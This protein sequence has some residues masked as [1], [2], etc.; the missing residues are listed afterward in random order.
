MRISNFSAK[1]YKQDAFNG[2]IDGYDGENFRMPE[3]KILSL[4]PIVIKFWS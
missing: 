4:F 3:T 1:V 2:K